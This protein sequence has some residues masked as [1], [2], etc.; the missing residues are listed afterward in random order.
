MRGGVDKTLFIKK[1]HHNI[2]VAQIYV[3]DIVFGSTDDSLTNEFSA[4]M[5]SEF[6]MSMVGEL[7]YFLGFQIKQLEIEIFISQSKYAKRLVKKFG[8]ES[9]KHSTTPMSTTTKLSKHE[10]EKDVDQTFFVV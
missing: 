3:D 8:L 4:C 2:L 6:Q 9:S 5:S 7:S 1:N 10:S